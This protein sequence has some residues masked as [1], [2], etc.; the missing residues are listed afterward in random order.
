M[1][2]T[3]D[4]GSFR[5]LIFST[6]PGRIRK[7][8]Y[9]A[10]WQTVSRIRPIRPR[11]ANPAIPFSGSTGNDV[12]AHGRNG[13]FGLFSKTGQKEGHFNLHDSGPVRATVFRRG[14]CMGEGLKRALLAPRFAG[15]GCSDRAQWIQGIFLQSMSGS[16]GRSVPVFFSSDRMKS[17]VPGNDHERDAGRV[18]PSGHGRAGPGSGPDRIKKVARIVIDLLL[19]PVHAAFRVQPAKRPRDRDGCR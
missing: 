8:Q 11:I 19:A 1:R 6:L 15:S 10:S 18:E 13:I 4:P 3:G 5:A 16:A 14:Y 2:K 9:P 7:V 17:V 12:H